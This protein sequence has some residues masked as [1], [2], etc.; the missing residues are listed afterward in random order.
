MTGQTKVKDYDQQILDMFIAKEEKE[1]IEARTR[2]RELKEQDLYCAQSLTKDVVVFV[3]GLNDKD[4][5]GGL[6]GSKV[7]LQTFFV[8]LGER[9]AK[10][11]YW[12]DHTKEFFCFL[13]Q[14]TFC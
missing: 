4:Q 7:T 10:G 1:T 13:S 14:G 8:L 6:K 3:W 9:K 11:L 12:L 5:L 2:R